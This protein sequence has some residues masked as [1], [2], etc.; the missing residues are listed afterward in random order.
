MSEVKGLNTGCYLEET[1]EAISADESVAIRNRCSR[2]SP[3]DVPDAT[4][5]LA[6]TLQPANPVFT[7]AETFDKALGIKHHI[8]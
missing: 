2:Y 6:N 3:L 7:I 5:A 1:T 4:V 8:R